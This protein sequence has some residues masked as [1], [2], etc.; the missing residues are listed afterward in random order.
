MKRG[1]AGAGD[2]EEQTP[3][4]VIA[5]S[6]GAAK[7]TRRSR[8]DLGGTS[9][10]DAPPSAA[11]TISQAPTTATDTFGLPSTIDAA[12]AAAK[13]KA[14]RIARELLFKGPASTPSSLVVPVVPLASTAVAMTMQDQIAHQIASASSLLSHVRAEHQP[15]NE[16]KAVFRPLLLDA[17]GRE[18]D[19]SGQLV[20]REGPI[21]TLVANVAQEKKKTNPYLAHRA[22]VAEMEASGTS[23]AAVDERLI[24]NNRDVKGRKSLRF[25]EA[26]SLVQQ[27][28]MLRAKEERKVIAGYTSGRKAPQVKGFSCLLENDCC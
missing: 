5:A 9:I 13:A 26:G 6:D 27:A 17:Q 7:K 28:D 10:I 22:P 21:K 24:V 18:I 2:D 25:V 3:V 23:I 12:I 16:R 20:K 8:F 1:R 14:D 11:P 4:A 15:S 19:E